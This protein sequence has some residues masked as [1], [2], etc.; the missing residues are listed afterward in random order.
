MCQITLDE[1]SSILMLHVVDIEDDATIL[2]SD[3]DCIGS[4][5]DD[6]LLHAA[7]LQNDAFIGR[8]SQFKLNG[9]DMLKIINEVA[10]FRR[11]ENPFSAHDQG[12]LPLLDQWKKNVEVTATITADNRIRA[13]PLHFQRGEGLLEY[14]LKHDTCLGVR[15]SLKTLSVSFGKFSDC[16]PLFYS[17]AIR[18]LF[19]FILIWSY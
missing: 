16:L 3:Y 17:V 1:E 5:A 6:V 15:F 4:L 7:E 18:A 8:L 12:L 9:L 19:Q 14:A 13:F 11:K 2:D 10:A